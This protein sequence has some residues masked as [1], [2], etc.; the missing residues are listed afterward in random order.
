MQAESTEV[1]PRRHLGDIEAELRA[2]LERMGL[3]QSG[4]TAHAAATMD[5]AARRAA[6]AALPFLSHDEASWILART[7]A[8]PHRPP[9]D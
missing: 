8:A 6:V 3:L 5:P 9:R 2:P 7:V 1:P 4:E